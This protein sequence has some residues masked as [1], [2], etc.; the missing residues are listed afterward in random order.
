MQSTSLPPIALVFFG[1]LWLI[2]AAGGLYF[3]FG[4]NAV[5]KR[6]LYPWFSGSTLILTLGLAYFVAQVPLVLMLFIAAAGVGATV[7]HVRATTFCPR[8]GRMIYRGMLVG[9]ADYCPRCGLALDRP[10][11][12]DSRQ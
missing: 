4:S 6:Q 12:P 5:D 10:P 2:W 8:C 3:W 9:R 11:N 7:L 1:A